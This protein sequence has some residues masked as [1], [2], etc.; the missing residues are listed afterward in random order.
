MISASR[1]GGR[2]VPARRFLISSLKSGILDSGDQA[3]GFDE[4]A[5]TFALRGENFPARRGEPVITAAALSWLLDPATADPAAFLEAIEQRIERRDI[6]PERAARTQ[7][8]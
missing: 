3:D 4:L 5:P 8:D 2:S 1:V 6:E 7:L